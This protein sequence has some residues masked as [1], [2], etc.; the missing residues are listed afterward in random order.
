MLCSLPRSCL[1]YPIDHFDSEGW[2]SSD[3]VIFLTVSCFFVKKHAAFKWKDIISGFPISS[4]SAEALVRWGGK[5]K[6]VLIA[7]FLSNICAKSC[8]NRT[9]YV[10]I[11]ASCKGGTFF[12]TQCRWGPSPP[13]FSAH[14]YYSYC[15]FVRTLHNRYWFAQ[16]QVLFLEKS[17]MV[18]SMCQY[19]YWSEYLSC[20]R[21]QWER[22]GVESMN[23]CVTVTKELRLRCAAL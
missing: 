13:K 4:G 3:L 10:N 23:F 2:F 15:D 6:Y 17:L 20:G 16:V 8:R 1:V 5:I 18:L 11:I 9:V 19:K 12:E 21:L 14:V 7:Y 22:T